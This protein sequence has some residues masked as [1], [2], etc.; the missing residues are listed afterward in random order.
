LA[1][2]ECID[3]EE[4]SRALWLRVNFLFG[5]LGIADARYAP[6]VL[7]FQTYG[8]ARDDAEAIL[9]MQ[10]RMANAPTQTERIEKF[11]RD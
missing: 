2:I 7:R 3:L 11:E 1:D 8:A 10:A 9:A 6:A 4:L 5:R